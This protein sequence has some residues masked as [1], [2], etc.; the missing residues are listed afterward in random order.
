MALGLT[1]ELVSCS[2]G[3]PIL[4]AQLRGDTAYREE[5]AEALD[6]FK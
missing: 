5:E 3:K 6:E 1:H 4:A 2:A